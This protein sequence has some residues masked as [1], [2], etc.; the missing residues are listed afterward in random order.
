MSGRILIQLGTI[1]AG[2]S[3]ISIGG[4]NVLIPEIHNQAVEVHRWLDDAT[5]ARLFAISQA[6]PGPNIMLA[7]IIGWH[8]A[9]LS[10]LLT[11]SIAILTPPAIIALFAG[12]GI[13]RWSEHRAIR[14]LT[15]GL[16]PVAL[17]LMLASGV[18]ASRTANA[19]LAGY[20][21]TA[22][23]ALA[24]YFTSRNPLLLMTIGTAAFIALHSV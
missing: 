8:I 20:A 21:I 2:L 23:V 12:R 24:M 5:F 18:V 3:L 13:R 17:G 9:G 1:F 14:L 10:G 4:A 7:S 16:V 15:L 19:G 11:A 22:G 6:A